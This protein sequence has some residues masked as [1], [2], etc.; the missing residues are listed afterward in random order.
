MP[1]KLNIPTP[2]D[3]SSTRRGRN[4][5]LG[6]FNRFDVVHTSVSAMELTGLFVY[7]AK[8]RYSDL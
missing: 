1:A 7:M 2:Y 6:P 5:W 8:R 4:A 3:T